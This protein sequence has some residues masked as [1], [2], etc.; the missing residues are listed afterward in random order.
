MFATKR[1]MDL[2]AELQRTRSKSHW[3]WKV[4]VATGVEKQNGRL[5]ETDRMQCLLQRTT[6]SSVA[7][8]RSAPTPA[9]GKGLRVAKPM[10]PLLEG[11][12]CSLAHRSDASASWVCNAG[13]AAP[14]PTVRSEQE[15]PGMA[16]FLDS[17]KYNSD[18][19]VAVIVQVTG[20]LMLQATLH[21]NK[22]CCSSG[23][24]PPAAQHVDTGE[25]LMQAFADRAA[26]NETMQTG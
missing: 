19:L 2:A 8:R 23:L 20:A 13:A 18:G 4:W 25:V 15:V 26:L 10:Q 9:A 11:S 22:C 12:S 1:E 21:A 17:L 3:V 14:M 6:G 7:S 5:A 16:K 24:S